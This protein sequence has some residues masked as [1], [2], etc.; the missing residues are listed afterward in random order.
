MHVCVFVRVE[1]MLLLS[2]RCR[3]TMHA[4][5]AVCEELLLL[6]N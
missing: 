2:Y 1:L 5:L 3:G 4:W 6:S